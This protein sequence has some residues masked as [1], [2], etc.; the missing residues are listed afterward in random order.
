[1]FTNTARVWIGLTDL[2]VQDEWKWEH[3]NIMATNYTNWGPTEPDIADEHCVMLKYQS[4]S[5]A[6]VVC[7]RS[8]TYMCQG[9]L[10]I[11]NEKIRLV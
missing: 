8:F 7:S 11:T 4:K 10:Y 1:M 9:K 5:W 3:S 2:D 6:D